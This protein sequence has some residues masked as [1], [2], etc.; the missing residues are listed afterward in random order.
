MPTQFTFGAGQERISVRLTAPRNP[1]R[2][3]RDA[4]NRLDSTVKLNMGAFSG[5]FKA[6]FTT[7]DLLVLHARLIEAITSPPKTI[8][9]K[10]AD[11][12]LSL[13]LEFNDQGEAI[14]SGTIQPDRLRQASLVFR[15]DMQQSALSQTAEEVEDALREFKPTWTSP[16][17]T[18]V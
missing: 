16:S 5:S 11:G 18:E 2:D 3:D 13:S 12:A 9:F 10:N 4:T 6:E 7:E 15:F 1:S 8:S 14:I 17:H